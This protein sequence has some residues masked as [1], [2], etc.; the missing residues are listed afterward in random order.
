MSSEAAAKEDTLRRGVAEDLRG[1]MAV[2]LCGSTQASTLTLLNR[3]VNVRSPWL[4]V[5]MESQ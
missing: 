5:F 1:T 2:K 4:K 3:L